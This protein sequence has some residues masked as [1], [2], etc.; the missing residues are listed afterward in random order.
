MKLA[1]NR[2]ITA[3]NLGHG[4]DIVFQMTQGV[5]IIVNQNN[6]DFL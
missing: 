1:L 4:R 3:S 6:I 5:G 2:L